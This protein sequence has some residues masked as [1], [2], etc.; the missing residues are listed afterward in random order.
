MVAL[1]ASVH[2]WLD[3]PEVD[4]D[5]DVLRRS[6]LAR[7]I[8]D[9]IV[10]GLQD[11][12]L[13]IG[14]YGAWGEG[15]STVLH[16]IE[17]FCR[18]AD[19]PVIWFNP[20]T[21]RDA[22]GLWRTL[23]GQV[24]ST[25]RARPS[26][27]ELAAE[28]GIRVLRLSDWSLRLVARWK[29]WIAELL[30]LEKAAEA[31]ARS[32]EGKRPALDQVSINRFL[33]KLPPHRRLVVLIDDLDRATPQLVPHLLLALREVFD[34][35]G[36]AFVLALDP[37]IVAREFPEVHPG[38][39]T[40][41]EFIEKIIQFPFWLPPPVSADVLRLTESALEK[42]P[43]AVDRSSVR[44]LADLLPRN[45]RRLKQFFRN[46][47]RLGDVIDRH[48]SDELRWSILRN[49][50]GLGGLEPQCVS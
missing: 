32:L 48:D 49:R 2:P 19:M 9:L 50:S 7:T 4:P 46:L 18:D 45:P 8:S 44:D 23:A 12:P 10:S 35:A 38:W 36:C 30:P 11:E 42:L 16:F 31:V 14:I 34:I 28:Y 25:L 26:W 39:G 47:V 43:V 22:A 3:Q 21:A 6:P 24:R 29:P 33:R 27:R 15:K 37:R 41:G 1:T 20:W 17:R 13:R 5:R 40:A